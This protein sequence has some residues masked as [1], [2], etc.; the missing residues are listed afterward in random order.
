[1]FVWLGWIGVAWALIAGLL[2]PAMAAAAPALFAGPCAAGPVYDPA[3][4]V[5][6][7][8]NA[9]CVFDLQVCLNSTIVP[10]LADCGPVSTNSRGPFPTAAT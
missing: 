4:D 1:M 5:D 7:L 2:V 6:G 3:C 8:R 9:V 10:E